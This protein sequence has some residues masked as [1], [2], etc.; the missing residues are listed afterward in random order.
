MTADQLSP[1]DVAF[2]CLE[3]DK[4]P[5]HL[6]AVAS[7]APHRPVHPARI[8]ALLCERAQ[9]ISKLR[10]RTQV[11][12]LP[13]GGASWVDDPRFAVEDHVTG[14]HLRGP[15]GEDRFADLVSTLMAQPLDLDRPPWEL[16][17][18]TGLA[19]GRF[20]VVVKLH[21]A[22]CDGLKAVGLG[23]RLLDDLGRDLP[24]TTESEPE[25][26]G[27]AASVFD[28]LKE[29]AGTATIASAVLRS[30]RTPGTR[31]PV[32]TRSPRP[33]QV[34]MARLGV[35]EVQRVRRRHG[36]TVNDVLLALVTGALR[37]WLVAHDSA[38]A[39]ATV[40]AL[41]PVSTRGRD[42]R[43]GGPGN[44]ISGFLC[45]LPVGEPDARERLRIVR[46]DM[47][48]HKAEGP[49]RGPGAL[50][51]LADRIPAALHRLATPLAGRCAP[52]LFDA[53]VTSVHL[54]ALPLTLDG[55]ELKEMYPV[56]PVAAGHAVGVALSVYR[57]GVHICL[58]TNQPWISGSR[59][60]LGALR[61]EL[62]ALDHADA[63]VDRA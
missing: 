19:G 56:A 29:L 18:I 27:L 15:G 32:L 54:P 28:S 16:H 46:A 53:L 21:H 62:A 35:D 12:W 47:D 43:G 5:M 51:L 55:A 61:R 3:D 36:G 9:E 30:A 38:G 26:V 44:Q 6:G 4:N 45:E 24:L 10:K 14:H 8:V 40:R 25:P 49:A 23:L 59:W 52:L 20:A 48:R 39:G 60:L 17:V 7:F 58:H 63:L 41:I 34:V 31:S 1:L 37:Q 13:L 50:P 42:P 22:L 11:S 2:L 33:R 57:S